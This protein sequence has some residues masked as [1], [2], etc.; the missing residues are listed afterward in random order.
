MGTVGYMSPEQ[1]SGGTADS[2]SDQFS[3]GLV[4]YEM[5]TG[6]RA[7]DRPTAV[8]TLSAII[9]DDPT[10]IGQLNPSVPAPVRWIVDRCLGEEAGGSVRVHARSGA[11]SGERARSFFRAD[12]LGRDQLCRQRR[13]PCA[14]RRRELVAWLL[15]A[16]LVLA[17]A[18]LMVPAASGDAAADRGRTVR[19]TIAPPE[20]VTFDSPFGTSPFAVSPDGRH[21]V[22]A[23]RGADRRARLWLH[24]FDSLVSRPLPGTEGAIR[25]VL[26]ARW[27][28]RRVLY[29]ESLEAQ[30]PSQV[31]M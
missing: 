25:S 4:L 13:P 27:P 17:A 18:G 7:F 21:L 10:P 19:F 14:S 24:S 11:G 30:R 15:V 20:N 3:F 29:G 9:R 31:E 2:R 8:E 23:G 12:E 28:L 6:Q 5:L 1:A 22:F 26:V 16:A